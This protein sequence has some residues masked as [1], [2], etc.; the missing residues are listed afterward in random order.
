MKR[1][2]ETATAETQPTGGWRILLD[3]RPVRI[4]GGPELALPTAT[5]AEAVAEEWQ[6]AGGG[7]GGETSYEALPLTRIAGTAQAR[8]APDPEPVVLE[9]ARYAETDLLCYR[10]DAPEALV[11]RQRELWQ[12]WVDWTAER[13][14][15]RLRVTTGIVHVPQEPE[16]LAALAAAV[17]A[18]GPH[19]LAA[20]G[21]AIPALGSL[22]LGL[23]LAEGLLSAAEAHA[24][25]LLDE[26]FQAEAWGYDAEAEARRARIGVEVAQAVRFLHLL[27]P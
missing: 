13:H 24:L 25:A 8:I 16:A 22:V 12:P 10:A 2:W 15:A 6:A 21:L 7:R 20:L 14:G 4:P 11:R 18:H 5:L 26:T 1:F 23:A 17:A 27:R 19:A 3:G 9:L